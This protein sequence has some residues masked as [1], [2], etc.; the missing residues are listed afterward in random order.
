[1]PDVS[2]FLGQYRGELLG[3]TGCCNILKGGTSW[4]VWFGAL[5][6]LALSRA[7]VNMVDEVIETKKKVWLRLQPRSEVMGDAATA[8]AW[9][10]SVTYL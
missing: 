9:N 3:G 7:G 5:F 2:Q 4:F 8:F 1:M 6:L 10:S